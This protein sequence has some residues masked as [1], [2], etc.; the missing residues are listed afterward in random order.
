MALFWYILYDRPGF[1]KWRLLETECLL[2]WVDGQV[3]VHML[4]RIERAFGHCRH[5]DSAGRGMQALHS[6]GCFQCLSE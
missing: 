5:G 4:Q 1:E 3:D 6:L 2:S